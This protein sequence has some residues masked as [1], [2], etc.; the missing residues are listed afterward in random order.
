MGQVFGFFRLIVEMSHKRPTIERMDAAEIWQFPLPDQFRG[1]E[2]ST[3]N[4]SASTVSLPRT[5]ELQCLLPW[6]KGDLA[7]P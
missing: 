6:E 3:P 1:F 2:L 4:C 7:M 5:A